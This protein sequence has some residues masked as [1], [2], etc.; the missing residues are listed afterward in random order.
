MADHPFNV[1]FLCTGNSARSI[2]AEA[3]LNKLGAGISRFQRGQPAQRMAAS[4]GAAAP[5]VAGLRHGALSLEVLE[6]ICRPRRPAARFRIHGLR[7]RGR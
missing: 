1:L 5:A 3:I 4:R 2:M 6:R 7:Q